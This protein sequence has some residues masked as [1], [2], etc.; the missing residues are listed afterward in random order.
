M[1]KHLVAFLLNGWKLI[2]GEHIEP[3]PPMPFI[4]GAMRLI[5]LLE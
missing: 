1:K 5:T 4:F 3:W 2:M